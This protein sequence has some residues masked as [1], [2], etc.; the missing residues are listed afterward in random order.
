VET[1][2]LNKYWRWTWARSK[3]YVQ[4]V[5]KAQFFSDKSLDTS[6]LHQRSMWPLDRYVL[7]S[8]EL[9][10]LS[11][12]PNSHPW[13]IQPIIT[14]HG[15]GCRHIITFGSYWKSL[16]TSVQHQCG[17]FSLSGNRFLESCVCW[18]ICSISIPE[19]WGIQSISNLSRF[20]TFRGTW[21]K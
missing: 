6:I 14:Y 19:E 3:L 5:M 20:F 16:D 1:I 17:T 21:L 2:V 8:P 11:S 7:Q 10:K 9:I 15:L 18:T 12:S 4:E 13:K